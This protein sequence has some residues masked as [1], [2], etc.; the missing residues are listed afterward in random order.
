[1]GDPWLSIVMPVWNGERYV[2]EALQSVREQGGDG[3]ELI[4]VDDGSTDGSPGI[5]RSWER[6]LPLRTIRRAR[7]GN[8][9]AATNVGLRE[10]RGTYVCFLHQDD[11]WLPGRLGAIA[12]EAASEPTLV[13]HPALFVGPEGRTL[14]EWR[15]PLP[16]GDVDPRLFAERILVQNF[17]AIPCAAF[18]RAAA[19]RGGGLDESLWYTADWDLWL[20]LA[21]LGRIRYLQSA[22]AAFR[23]HAGSQTVLRNDVGERRRQLETV[24]DRHRANAAPGAWRAA[25]FSVEVNIALAALA[26]GAAP[27]WR[28]LLAA[29]SRLG[30]AGSVRYLRDSRIAERLGARLRLRF[31]RPRERLAG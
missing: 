4:A 9:V 20:R 26:A 7:G 11:L 1:M 12:R 6:L 19:L 31:S 3:Y 23:V 13:L 29:F 14:G 27:P 5:L 28:P 18:L 15:C 17:V 10:A 24:L 2:G 30:P 21:A 16:A 8:W 25:R 22:F